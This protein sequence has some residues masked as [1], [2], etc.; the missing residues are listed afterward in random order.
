MRPATYLSVRS[1]SCNSFRCALSLSWKATLLHNL[2][3]SIPNL[4]TA[5]NFTYVALCELI[6]IVFIR[7]R[8]FG[9]K[10]ANTVPQLLMSGGIVLA[11]GVWLGSDRPSRERQSSTVRK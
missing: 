8:F 11:I 2:P 6:T 7:Y 9:S 4:G 3:F 5:P 10:R 1:S